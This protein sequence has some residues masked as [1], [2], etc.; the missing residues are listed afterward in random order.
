MEHKYFIYY[1]FFYHVK[2]V[3]LH[4]RQFWLN[5]EKNQNTKGHD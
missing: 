3:Y 5:K 1:L 4:N 2:V